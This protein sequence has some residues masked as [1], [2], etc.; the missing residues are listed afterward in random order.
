MKKSLPIC[1]AVLLAVTFYGLTSQAQTTYYS[2]NATSGGNWDDV[3][4]WTTNSDGSGGPAA[5]IPGRIDNVV[6]LNG[7]VIIINNVADNGSAGVTPENA[8]DP[9]NNIAEPP[10]QFPGHNTAKF[11]QTGD[12][13][14]QA[15][16]ELTSSVSLML[17]GTTITSGNFNTG[18]GDDLVNLGRL[19]VAA[20]VFSIG[21]DFI[22]SGNS[23]TNIDIASVA[24]DDLYLDDTDALLCGLGTLSIP[25]TSTI[26]TYNGAN[27]TTQICTTFS[28][29]G[30]DICPF[31]GGG[32]F[33]LPVELI[34]FDVEV[35]GTS[36]VVSWATASE[37][38][39][40]FFAIE[41]SRDG[42]TFEQIGVVKGSGTT[43]GEINYSFIDEYPLVGLSYY[44]LKQQDFDGTQ[45]IFETVPLLF[46]S[47]Q[48]SIV[49]YPN[50][51]HNRNF[52]LD[53]F[54][55]PGEASISLEI[56]D[57]NG[58]TLFEKQ[59]T[60]DE[61]GTV[62]T[63]IETG[64]KITNGMYYLKIRKDELIMYKRIVFI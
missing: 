15:G 40:D 39:N 46:N 42:H 18:G 7:H 38:N 57:L 14:V 63:R 54:G 21:D 16:G 47:N 1:I 8:P 44:R 3:N 30:C 10:Q 5:S 36:S 37:I 17:G 25:F 59:V 64:D 50:P 61:L 48:V 34:F 6:I 13:E 55:M 19:D 51:V 41:R 23:E 33:I 22:L 43:K 26:K 53:L 4:S 12:I 2:R 62:T 49:A 45:E 24:T 28:I 35:S 60:T 27:E 29:L 58:G 56:I 9:N 32:D 11:Y 52:H 31:T 20:G